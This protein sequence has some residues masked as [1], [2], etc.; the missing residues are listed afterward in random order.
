MS[1][2]ENERYYS[3]PPPSSKLAKP[4]VPPALPPI[5]TSTV[6]AEA[7][8]EAEHLKKLAHQESF[9]ATLQALNGKKAPGPELLAPPPKSN[10]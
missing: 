1:A 6:L 9:L 5:P 7:D 10:P 4:A 8:Q 3:D 2:I